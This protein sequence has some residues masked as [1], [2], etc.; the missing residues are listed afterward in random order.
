MARRDWGY[1][2][3]HYQWRWWERMR[4]RCCDYRRWLQR[5]CRAGRGGPRRRLVRGRRLLGFNAKLLQLRFTRYEGHTV[6][7][8]ADGRDPRSYG[9]VF[10]T[11]WNKNC[12][13]TGVRWQRPM[14]PTLPRQSSTS[15]RS[16]VSESEPRPTLSRPAPRCARVL[17]PPVPIAPKRPKKKRSYEMV[18]LPHTPSMN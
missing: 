3:R 9:D 13:G 18:N 14:R 4:C 17:W 11:H 12:G 1:R 7:C 5:P 15:R 10:V 2:L 8:G 16:A 6:E